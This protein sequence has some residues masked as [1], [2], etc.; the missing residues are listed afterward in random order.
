MANFGPFLATYI[1]RDD[2]D[3]ALIIH[4][5]LLINVAYQDFVLKLIS[6]AGGYPDGQF[7]AISGHFWPRKWSEIIQTVLQSCI[8]YGK[9]MLLYKILS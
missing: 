6:E 4:F 5:I 9:S 2:P 1:V 7:W 3:C 8:L